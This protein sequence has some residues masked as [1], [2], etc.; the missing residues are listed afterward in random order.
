M[1]ELGF[2]DPIFDAAVWIAFVAPA[3]TPT[4]ILQTLTDEIRKVLA[5]PDVQVQLAERGLET[6]NNTPE[7]FRESYRQEFEVITRRMKDFGIEPQ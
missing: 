5:M 6:I 3:N 7:Q 1:R 4:A 2:D